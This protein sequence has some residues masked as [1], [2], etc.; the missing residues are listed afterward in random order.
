MDKTSFPLQP[1]KVAMKQQQKKVSGRY[2]FRAHPC[3][4]FHAKGSEILG[5]GPG[6][7]HWERPAFTL[8]PAMVAIKQQQKKVSGRSV[9]HAWVACDNN[10]RPPC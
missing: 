5:E 8:Q 2:A 6:P 10:L 7:S 9:R 1:A 3:L 4:L